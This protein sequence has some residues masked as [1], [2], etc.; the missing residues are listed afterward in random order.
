MPDIFVPV[1]FQAKM[2]SCALI[3]LGN[4]INNMNYDCLI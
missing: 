2:R 1:L 3:V 4:D